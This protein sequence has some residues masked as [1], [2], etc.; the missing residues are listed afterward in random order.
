MYNRFEGTVMINIEFHCSE[1][2]NFCDGCFVQAFSYLDYEIPMHNHDFYEVNIVLQGTGVHCI[3]KGSI[4][5]QRGDVFV[6]PPMVAHAYR[7]A[8]KLEVYHILLQKNFV[9]GNRLE[10]ADVAGFLQLMEIEPFLRGK[11]TDA[12]FLH[13]QEMQILQLENDLQILDNKSIFSR[14]ICKELKYHTIWKLLYWF[15]F[16]LQQQTQLRPW[17]PVKY[18]K[19]ILLA[20]EYIHLHYAERIVLED[21]CRYVFL[22]RSTFLRAFQ[23]ICGVTPSVYLNR[24]RCKKAQWLLENIDCTRT[25]AAHNTGFYDLSHMERTLKKYNS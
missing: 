19:Q 5:V 20:L 6:I 24:Y 1:P 4:P 25:E 16:L 7:N 12:C 11:Y 9:D 3:E 17:A 23:E 15:S 22:S 18:E 2:D 21:L 13:L 14:K 10:A 8:D